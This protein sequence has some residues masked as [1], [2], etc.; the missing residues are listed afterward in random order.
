MSNLNL[1][2]I[3]I[4]IEI[5]TDKNLSDKEKIIY[6][7]IMF[8]SKHNGYCYFTNSTINKLLDISTTQAS[9]WI[10]SLKKKGYIQT[11]MIYKENS[12]QIETR[13]IIPILK[14]DNTYL[15]KVKY[16]SSTKFGYHIQEKLKDNKYN[17]NISNEYSLNRQKDNDIKVNFE[18]RD[19]IGFDFTKLYSN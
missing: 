3:W 7:V 16:A 15:R 13:K 1:K 2:G 19:Y 9:T 11:Q 6:S 17:K 12:K 5:L 10:N 8:L 14:N 18:Q 4:P